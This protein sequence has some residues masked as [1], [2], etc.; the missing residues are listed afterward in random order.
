M[1]FKPAT[2]LALSLT[3][4]GSAILLMS[5][6]AQ[7]QPYGQQMQYAPN[8]Q[9]AAPQQ[10]NN[11]I[12]MTLFQVTRGQDGNQYVISRSGKPILVPGLNIAPNAQNISVYRDQANNFWYMNQYGQP[13]KVT[14]TQIQWVESQ[15]NPQGGYPAGAYPQGT[16]PAPQ[17]T[18]VVNQQPAQQGSTSSSGMGAGGTALLTG[19]SAAAGAALGTALTEP[20]YNYYH[21]IPYGVPMYQDAYGKPYYTQPG[22]NK[23]Y[24]NNSTDQHT[25]VMNQW[26]GQKQWNPNNV[27]TN[28][29]IQR[30]DGQN[31][32]VQNAGQGQ[33]DDQGRRTG[34][35]GGGDNNQGQ[36][37]GGRFGRSNNNN[38]PGGGLGGANAAN[39][40]NNDGTL[41]GMRNDGDRG[42]KRSS[43]GFGGRSSGGFGG[44]SGGGFGGRG[45][46]LGGRRG[47]R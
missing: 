11:Q 33:G 34:R 4:S 1:S 39:V 3:V 35:F 12:G 23:V 44:R 20:D 32:A 45:G 43:G 36:G 18:V 17:Q 27:P 46:G 10:A 41:G 40:G 47:G 24:V 16:Q 2:L 7:A 13:T 15:I 19:V 14:E 25:A 28:Q 8:Q 21:G 29:P 9:Y 6:V 31:P 37:D 42:S 5:Q 30:A 22:G 38:N 26:N